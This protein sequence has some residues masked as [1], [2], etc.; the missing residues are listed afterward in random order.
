MPILFKLFYIMETD[1]ILPDTF[2]EAIVILILKPHKAPTKKENYNS[3]SFMNIERKI[4]N[5][6][7]KD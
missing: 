6:I 4:L 2:Y 3:I 7:L 1:G 5:K